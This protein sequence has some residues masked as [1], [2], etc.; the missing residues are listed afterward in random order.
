MGIDFSYNIIPK[1]KNSTISSNGL[2]YIKNVF[3]DMDA[4]VSR[5]A[6]NPNF[7]NIYSKPYF[8]ACSD[9]SNSIVWGNAIYDISSGS[10]FNSDINIYNFNVKSGG[11]GAKYCKI[12]L[13][14][15]PTNNW[16]T[17]RWNIVYYDRDGGG[18]SSY[19][20]IANGSVSSGTPSNH[21]HYTTNVSPGSGLYPSMDIDSQG[22]PHIAFFGPI[23]TSGNLAIHYIDA[24]GNAP[25]SQGQWNYT[26]IKDFGVTNINSLNGAYQDL[27]NNQPISLKISPHCLSTS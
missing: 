9:V 18:S 27:S 2:E 10:N 1:F 13:Y 11:N 6:I 15:S 26:L 17:T 25:I 8:V 24:T 20:T 12:K 22:R 16:L 4:D 14:Q 7:N 5:N 21:Y 23:S 3:V 19:L